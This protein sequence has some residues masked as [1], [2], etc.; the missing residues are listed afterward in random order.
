VI[1]MP[2]QTTRRG[3]VSGAETETGTGRSLTGRALLEALRTRRSVAPKRLMA[4]GPD[5]SQLRAIIGVGLS[6]PDHGKLR[7]WRFLHVSDERRED[8]AR[9]FG[10][11][12]LEASP[13]ASEAEL[14]RAQGRAL[15]SPT[16]L[17]AILRTVPAHERVSIDEQLISMGAALQNILLA[18]HALGFAAMITSG[19]KISSRILQGSFCAATNERLMCFVSI[20][21]PAVRARHKDIPPFEE[22]FASWR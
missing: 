13:D 10:K 19:R 22:H 17:A 14:E 18:S 8:L 5:A 20:G 9:L 6:A 15:N 3:D 4:P 1:A 12:K 11:A 7:P 16:V 2:F 21:T